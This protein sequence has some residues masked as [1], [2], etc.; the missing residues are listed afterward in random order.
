MQSARGC[1]EKLHVHRTPVDGIQCACKGGDAKGQDYVSVTGKAMARKGSLLE[2]GQL[3]LGLENGCALSFHHATNL[4][5]TWLCLR[6]L[7]QLGKSFSTFI[8]R[9]DTTHKP[10]AAHCVEQLELLARA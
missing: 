10:V 2:W 6:Q 4:S 1:C 5:A 3:L 9:K 8:L 7:C